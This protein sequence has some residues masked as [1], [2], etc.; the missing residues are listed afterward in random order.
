MPNRVSVSS[1]EF[2]RNIGYWQNKALR[3]PISI[4]HHGRERLILAAPD[5]F[6]ASA[7]TDDVAKGLAKLRSDVAAVQENLGDGYLSF[8]AQ[9]VVRHSNSVAEAFVGMSREDLYG[10]SI[11]NAL[12]QP[13]ASI[14]SDRVQRVMRTRQSEH[15]EIGAPDGRYLLVTVFPVSV[16]AAALMRNITEQHV[17]QQRLEDGEALQQAVRLHSRAA[18][19][20]LDARARV[21]TIDDTFT[22]W[23]GF[24]SSDLAGHRV[25]DLVAASQRRE[26]AEVIERVLRDGLG[27]TV[28]VTL[29]SKR[30]EEIEGALALAPILTDLTAH[31]A[32]ALFVPFANLGSTQR[33]A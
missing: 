26:A 22:A 17:L 25:I 28:N 15:F 27:R 20:K 30:G 13:F 2:I 1:A 8:D 7:S 33:A 6:E 16:G 5:A 11:I 31:G 12:P 4:T 19:I 29:L 18:A 14:L 21:E 23:T 32:C 10:T 3:Q 24:V 9:L